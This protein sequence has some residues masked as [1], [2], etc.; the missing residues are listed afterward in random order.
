MEILSS[1]LL[2]TNSRCETPAIYKHRREQRQAG[3]M[4]LGSLLLVCSLAH[5]PEATIRGTFPLLK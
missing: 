1:L 5:Q 4:E 2:V 3:A